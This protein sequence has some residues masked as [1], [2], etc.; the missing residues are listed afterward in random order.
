MN[1]CD[2]ISISICIFDSLIL[3]LRCGINKKTTKRM[4][5]LKVNGTEDYKSEYYKSEESPLQDNPDSMDSSDGYE[6]VEDEEFGEEEHLSIPEGFDIEAEL[7]RYLNML[8]KTNPEVA[9][10]I[11]K[12]ITIEVLDEGDDA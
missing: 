7:K 10:Q 9:D 5:N 11:E 4:E 2:V 12:S 8:R 6:T 3:T 1:I